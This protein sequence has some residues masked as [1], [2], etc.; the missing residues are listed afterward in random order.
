MKKNSYPTT[1]I[2]SAFMLVIFIILS[3]VTFA[4]MSLT[5]AN[6]DYKFSRRIADRNTE[7]YTASNRAEELLQ[8]IDDSIRYAHEIHPESYIATALN[9]IAYITEID[10]E[11]PEGAGN[12]P[13]FSFTVPMNEN[14]DLKVTVELFP[15]A[16][17]TD[18]YYR[19]L[20]W[21]EVSTKGWSADTTLKL[22]G[23]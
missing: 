21:Q 13:T 2:G 4:T 9:D 18:S 10:I 5:S 6:N 11:I 8:S 20:R 1:N 3:L 12:M 16:Q 23:G 22:I 15:L 14:T 17:L 19:V 7:Y